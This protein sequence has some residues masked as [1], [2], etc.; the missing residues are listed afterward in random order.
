V[1]ELLWKL[2]FDVH[3]Y[4]HPTIGWMEDILA[5]TTGDCRA[6]YKTFY[7]PNNATVV[8]VGD[9]SSAKVLSLVQKDYGAI[10]PQKI[11]VEKLTPEPKQ[12]R[13]K[14]MVIEKPTP[15]G[16]VAIGYRGPAL[17]EADHVALSVLSE[18]LFGGRSAR[19][20]RD[21]V[22][23]REL[24]IDVSGSVSSF[25]HPGLY[26]VYGTAR[27]GVTAEQLLR[28]I[29]DGLAEVKTRPVTEDERERAIARMELS[30]VQSLETV[31]GRAEQIG[32]YDSVLGDPAGAMSR[33]EAMRKATTADLARV[34]AQYLD[35]KQRTVI[36]VNPSESARTDE[37]AE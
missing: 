10:A 7:S 12:K 28:A 37:A 21:L 32:F 34:A 30:F 27:E 8:V 25:A 3:P 9:F 36:V 6:F 15:T 24:A 18:A 33:L 23:E 19:L 2:A 26:E 11:P 22:T 13:E 16:K 14:R 1:N 20:Y 17:G 29:D 35:D 31:G 5:F 4:H